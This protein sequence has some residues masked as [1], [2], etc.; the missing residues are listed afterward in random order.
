MKKIGLVS[1]YFK[2]NYGS[3]LQAY[4]SQKI[5]ENYGYKVETINVSKNKDFSKGKK[6]YYIGQIFNFNF[7]KTKFGMVKLKIDKKINKE[8]RENINIRNKKYAQFK[9][10]YNLTPAYESYKKLN[11]ISRQYEAIVVGSDQLW[12]P[13]N[14]IADYYT[15]NWVPDDVK[16]ISY[17]TSFGISTIPQKYR[18]KYKTFLDRIDYIS[19]R[20]DVGQKIIK[21]LTDRNVQVVC[22][23]TL[24]FNKEEWMSI[25]EEKPIYEEKYILCYFLGNSIEY[26]K[27]AERLKEKTKC[28]IVSLNH[29]D[30]YVKYSDI[31]ADETPYDIGPS[32]FLN[33][34]RNAEFVCTDSFHG[35][36]FSLINNKKFFCF[37]RHNKKSKNSTNSRLDSLLS[38]VN[39]T[40]RLLSGNEEIDKVLDMKINYDLVNNELESFRNDSKSFLENALDIKKYKEELKKN[41]KKHI[42]IDNK[43]ECCGCTAC[44]NICPKNAIEMITDKEGFLYPEVD[45]EKCVKCG[46]CKKVCPI[47]NAKENKKEQH[48]YI[49]QNKDDQVRR[50]STS[51][52]AFTAIAEY[53]LNKNGVVFGVCFDDDFNVIHKGI[54]N[55]DE[56]WRFRNSKYVQSNPLNTFKEVK[57]NLEADRYVCYSGTSCQIEGLKRFLQKDYEKLVLVDVVCRAVPSPLV[58][59]KYLELR[60]KEYKDIKNIMFRDKYYG[61]KYSNFSIYNKDN[62]KEKEYHSGVETDPY[63][64]AFF[65]NICDRPSCYECKFKK[66]NRESDIT[67]WDCFEVEKYNKKLDDDKGTTRI[68]ANSI[69]GNRIISELAKT[70]I[71]E[72]ITYEEATKGFLAMFQSVRNNIRREEFFEDINNLD[73]KDVFKK[74]FPNTI[75]CKIEKN[76][77]I[78]LIKLGIYKPLLNLGKKIRKRS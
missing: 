70:N 25:Q 68:L 54:E 20:E 36:V 78:F 64:R 71:V 38:R 8:L 39:L 52:G 18:E 28:K 24:L 10:V 15:L 45:E 61:Y 9:E 37:R 30:E 12:L 7:I 3:Q 19:T 58:W 66:G 73:S 50:E 14:V 22:D 1:C 75:K 29:C 21:D 49:F 26:R 13:V 43:V 35:T 46:L 17:S 41:Y 48:A 51:G 77:R 2:D 5:L 34:I 31:F 40:E 6:K 72:E 56:L 47:I 65:S 32:E 23:P 16:K 59:K 60:K 33:L 53:V 69:K 55:K 67:I 76:A 74:Y 57:E 4:A 44:K 63:L 62:N 42:I 27:F 11:E